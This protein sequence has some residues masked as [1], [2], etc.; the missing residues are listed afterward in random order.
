MS[1]RIT[2]FALLLAAP[3]LGADEP[4]SPGSAGNLAL[5]EKVSAIFTNSGLACGEMRF[6]APCFIPGK[7]S[8][9]LATTN[10]SLHPMHP[11]LF[12]PGNFRENSFKTSLV[13]LGDATEQDLQRAKGVPLD[14][15]LIVLNFNCGAN[16]MRLLRFGPR[17]FVFL[18]PTDTTA[19]EAWAKVY[20]TEVAVPRFLVSATEAAPLINVLKESGGHLAASIQAEPSRWENKPLRNLWAIIP[21]SDERLARE[22][23]VIL[24]PLDANCVAPGL[25]HGAQ[26]AANLDLLLA[27]FD[28]FRKAPP[29]RTVVLAAVNAHTQKYLGERILAWNLLMPSDTVEKMN[30]LLMADLQYEE[31]LARTF[32]RFRLDGPGNY[33]DSKFAEELSAATDNSLG[34]IVQLKDPLVT[35]IQREAGRLQAQISAGKPGAHAGELRKQL[36]ECRRLTSLFNTMGRRRKLADLSSNDISRLKQFVHSLVAG[37][38]R[39]AALNRRD[40]ETEIANRS[41]LLALAGKRIAFVLSLDLSWRND[42]IGFYS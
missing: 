3:L 23:V 20:A 18:E 34:R 33:E 41:I 32:S 39:L 30:D 17:G 38:N 7:T 4:R 22:A 28:S 2:I 12:R 11:T 26:S 27:M 10:I 21:G 14:N 36:E 40:L 35:S 25:A 8:L 31:L 13:F 19:P 29:A 42:R 1:G 37:S 15:A 9:S 5:E 24:A 16:W 6:I